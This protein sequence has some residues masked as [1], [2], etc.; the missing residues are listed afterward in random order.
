MGLHYLL[1]LS[2]YLFILFFFCFLFL[3]LSLLLPA[4]SSW[5]RLP[6]LAGQVACLILPGEVECLSLAG[7]RLPFRQVFF[8]VV[9]ILRACVRVAVAEFFLCVVCR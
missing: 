4:S 9:V 6:L 2:Y 1:L 3:L 5:G 7:G 8:H